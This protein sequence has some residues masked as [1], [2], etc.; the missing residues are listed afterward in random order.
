M[1][2]PFEP[3]VPVLG[4]LL[5]LAGVGL[6]A[7]A[8]LLGGR[9]VI[10]SL[11]Q[12]AYDRVAAAET[13]RL[14]ITPAFAVEVEPELAAELI[15]A[16]HPR[17]RRGVDP[18]RVGWPALELRAV[19][20]NGQ[21][22][23]QVDCPRQLAASVA[24]AIRTYYPGAEVEEVERA[25]HPPAA[26]VY[27]HLEAPDVWPLRKVA[28]PEGRPLHRLA[29]ALDTYAPPAAEVRFR[30]VLRPLPAH[31]W[32]SVIEP[33]TRGTSMMALV[34]GALADAILFRSSSGDGGSAPVVLSPAEREARQRKRSGVVGFG[35]GLALEVARV[36][37]D[38]ARALL[39]RLA[40]F[41][42]AAA[43]ARQRVGWRTRRG[44]G[45]PVSAFGRLADWEVA[46]LWYLPEASF[47][48]AALP[49]RRA[50]AAPVPAPVADTR[51]SVVVGRGSR[52]PLRLPAEQLARHM[53]VIGATGSGKSTLLLTL[54]LGVLDTPM[55]ATVIDPHGDLTDDLL[56]R[57]PRAAAGR[58]HVL[59]LADRDHP[60]GFNFLERRSADEGQLV[61]SEF[62]DMFEDLWPRFCG[63]KMQHYLRHALLTL[64][65]RR[66]PQTIIELVRLLTDD[67]FRDGYLRELSDPMLAAFWRNEWPGPRERERDSSIKAVLNKL[68]AFVA[69]DSIRHVVGQGVST[70]RPRGL[71]DRGDLLLVDLSRVGG[72]NASLFGAMLVSRYYIDAV[73]RQGRPRESRRQH[74]LI[75][76]EAQRFDT[77]ALARIGVEGRKFGLA[78]VLATQSLA[79]LAERLR[80][81]ILTNAATLALLSPGADDVRSIGRLL[82]PLTPEQLMDLRRFELVLRMPG[83]E[84]RLGV[85][86]GFVEPPAEGDPDVASALLAASDERD[87]RPLP[88]VQE[89]VRRRAADAEPDGTR[90]ARGADLPSAATPA[91]AADEE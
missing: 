86:G 53:V 87:A 89:E 62:V 24:V 36:D 5:P 44:G 22:A 35:A 48:R 11:R 7:A 38:V 68:G 12:A 37:A 75:V 72:D 50:L 32:R 70:L 6:A 52:G 19:W 34:A 56:S 16:L 17:Q 18:F 67:R 81:T 27:G 91:S 8:A 73:G 40:D 60:R 78:L 63:P 30:V 2:K 33:E 10:S 42:D 43:E 23:W 20:R 84:G 58:I 54:A 14:E 79:G 71:M 69:Y 57:V 31:R 25:D 3:L 82:A 64:L 76:D 88:Q 15:R 47:D 59:R 9:P 29:R 61:T 85:F 13:V 1:D 51:S 65:A 66:E 55:G 21:L 46:Q 4:E 83:P 80:E 26:A 90:V 49:R 77:R 28:L 74:L 45:A 39:W 41:S